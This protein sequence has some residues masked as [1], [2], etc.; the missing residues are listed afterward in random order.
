MNLR[1]DLASLLGVTCEEAILEALET[2]TN[3][4]HRIPSESVI[5]CFTPQIG[6]DPKLTKSVEPQNKP[7][8][9][10]LTQKKHYNMNLSTKP[11]KIYRN[12]WE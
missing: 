2:K 6:C 8:K 10:D 5:T 4:S 11:I 7:Q 1:P 12:G 9:I 3:A